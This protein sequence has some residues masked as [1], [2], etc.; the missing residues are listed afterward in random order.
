MTDDSENGPI[1]NVYP[2]SIG[3]SLKDTVEL[4]SRS[5]VQNCFCSLYCLPTFFHS[6]IDRGFS[7]IDYD[8]N[9]VLVSQGDLKSLSALNVSLK[10]DLVL[11]HLSVASPQFCDLLERGENSPYKD[12][13][14]DWNEFWASNGEM[15]PEGYIVPKEEHLEKLFLRKPGFPILRVP[16]PDGSDRFYWNTFYQEVRFEELTL[17][18][19]RSFDIGADEKKR[20]LL[21]ANESLS[22]GE[23]PSAEFLGEFTFSREELKELFRAKR[24]Y[25]GQMDVNARSEIVWQFYEEIF[26][27][28]K[29]YGA[30]IVRLDAF[31]YLHKSP[32]MTNFF[33]TPGTWEYLERLN[34]L[35]ERYNLTLLPEIHSEYGV[36]LHRE[37]SRRGYLIYDFFFPG[38]VIEALERGTNVNLL[39]WI[40]EILSEELKTINMLGCHDGIPVLDLKGSL[41]G[42]ELLTEQEIDAVADRII[43]R[44]GRV[45][46]LYG[47][48]GKR[49]AYYQ[50]NATFFSA[51][52]ED[53]EKLLI[54]RALQIFM[55]GRP[56][57]WYLDLFAGRNDYQA[58][59]SGKE[60]GHKAINR[61]NL[62][63]ED[64]EL[65]LQKP[66]VLEQLK[67]LRLRN[68]HRAFA[69]KLEIGETAPHLIHLTW[70]NGEHQASLK[71]DLARKVFKIHS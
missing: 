12:F 5:E 69:G 2:D 19:I 9:E 68:A 45:K 65:G 63:K 55:P 20:F 28:L 62:T 35:G 42:R 13:F 40:K 64:V 51:L 34:G 33:N 36:G 57:V 11:N 24:H 4:L 48:D 50:V 23:E 54:A 41:E 1:L 27:K 71:V 25:L 3:K 59:D 32:G 58:A 31:A 49:I 26:H 6:D 67:L 22:K 61:T 46:N 66:V 52:G 47:P 70:K 14:I 53:E 60:S 8:M 43:S 17:E 7:V 18:D 39:K 30:K 16:F 10:F 44:G 29:E 15:G 21:Q 56:Q 37:L 38:L